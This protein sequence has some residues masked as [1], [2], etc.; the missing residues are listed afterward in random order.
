VAPGEPSQADGI[1][2][3]PKLSGLRYLEQHGL[4]VVDWRSRKSPGLTLGRGTD[5]VPIYCWVPLY[6]QA[7]RHRYRL[8]PC[9]AVRLVRLSPRGRLPN[10]RALP[11]KLLSRLRAE[12]LLA[13]ALK[14]DQLF[15][16]PATRVAHIVHTAVNVAVFFH[17]CGAQKY[18]PIERGALVG[19]TPTT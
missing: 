9:R 15:D 1:S 3:T 14:F 16:Q 13:K 8:V 6:Y 12:H 4:I 17:C 5:W 11:S 7:N 18:G 2:P 10:Q 19:T